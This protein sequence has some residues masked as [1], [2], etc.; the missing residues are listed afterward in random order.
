[1]TVLPTVKEQSKPSINCGDLIL[2]VSCGLQLK[3]NHL[4]RIKRLWAI[5][6]LSILELNIQN[7]LFSVKLRP[8][9]ACTHL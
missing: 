9:V 6:I 3:Q 4:L 5:K 1:M 7:S 2:I 8:G